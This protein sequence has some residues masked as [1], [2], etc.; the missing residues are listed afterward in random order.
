MNLLSSYIHMGCY[1]WWIW[2]VIVFTLQYVWTLFQGKVINDAPHVNSG[3]TGG[4]V[5]LP[6]FCISPQITSKTKNQFFKLYDIHFLPP[7]SHYPLLAPP[8]PPNL[9]ILVPPLHVVVHGLDFKPWNKF[10]P[11]L[12]IRT[13]N[14]TLVQCEHSHWWLLKSER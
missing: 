10:N 11:P 14:F 8:P 3:G 2:S 6:P 13:I 1:H 7:I 4:G 9:K 5:A 12:W